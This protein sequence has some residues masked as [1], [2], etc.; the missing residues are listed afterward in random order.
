MRLIILYILCALLDPIAYIE[1]HPIATIIV[2]I[3]GIIYLII[4]T[5]ISYDLS[6]KGVVYW[7]GGDWERMT[8]FMWFLIQILTTPAFSFGIWLLELKYP[9][10]EEGFD[11]IY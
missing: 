10:P 8:E 7:P 11:T 2:G 5:K 3:I 4:G 1:M 6:Y 9:A